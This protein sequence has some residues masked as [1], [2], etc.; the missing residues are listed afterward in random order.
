[1][2]TCVYIMHRLNPLLGTKLGFFSPFL[3]SN[4]SRLNLAEAFR[5][6]YI[7]ACSTAL[8]SA[9]E[10]N[11]SDGHVTVRFSSKMTQRS[12][13]VDGLTFQ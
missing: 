8:R 1:M 10:E 11:E 6:D 13:T 3:I 9:T 5:N 12:S 7:V 4:S 2:F